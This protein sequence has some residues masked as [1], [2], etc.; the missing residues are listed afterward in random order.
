L[1]VS[2]EKGTSF[3]G[4]RRIGAADE[5]AETGRDTGCLRNGKGPEL[6]SQTNNTEKDKS[7]EATN[8]SL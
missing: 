4:K 1:L 7:D 8:E 2:R 6:M 5:A 3:C